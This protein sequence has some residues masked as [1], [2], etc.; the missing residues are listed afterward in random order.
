MRRKVFSRFQ[1]G[2]GSLLPSQLRSAVE[3]LLWQICHLCSCVQQPNTRTRR[4]GVVDA[5]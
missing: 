2:D 3:Q 4:I 1:I 5:P